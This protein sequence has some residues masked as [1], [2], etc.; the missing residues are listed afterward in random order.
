MSDGD[1]LST[2]DMESALRSLDH[3]LDYAG[4]WFKRMVELVFVA[5]YWQGMIDY[6]CGNKT[7]PQRMHSRFV[8]MRRN[9]QKIAKGLRPMP[10][11]AD[12]ATGPRDQ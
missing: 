12:V 3:N 10:F 4:A 2:V 7:T 1:P 11:N 9:Y 8:E 6:R 5:G